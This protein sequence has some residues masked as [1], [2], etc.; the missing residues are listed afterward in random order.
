MRWGKNSEHGPPTETTEDRTLAK[1]EALG[2]ELKNN[3]VDYN[4]K[5]D[6]LNREIEK[7]KKTGSKLSEPE[8]CPPGGG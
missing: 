4:A 2:I 5:V 3:A 8:E 7:L 1:L 6:D